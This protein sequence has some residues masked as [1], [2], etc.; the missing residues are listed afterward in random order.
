M[1]GPAL[2]CGFIYHRRRGLAP[3]SRPAIVRGPIQ[4][5]SVQANPADAA[6]TFAA[7]AGG[8]LQTAGLHPITQA[9]FGSIAQATRDA[10]AETIAAVGARASALAVAAHLG[11]AVGRRRWSAPQLACPPLL[12]AAIPQRVV[13]IP[14]DPWVLAPC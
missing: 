9:D 2:G 8:C 10:N 12:A 14:Y 3:D 4:R 13:S 11:V 5:A 6:G 7:E 1:C